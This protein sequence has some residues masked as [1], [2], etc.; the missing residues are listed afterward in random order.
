MKSYTILSYV[1]ILFYITCHQALEIKRLFRHSRKFP[2]SEEDLELTSCDKRIRV[3]HNISTGDFNESAR[4]EQ[5]MSSMTTEEPKMTEQSMTM[6]TESND[7]SG[8]DDS[9]ESGDKDGEDATESSEDDINVNAKSAFTCPMRPGDIENLESQCVAEYKA[10]KKAKCNMT[11]L[12]KLS[13]ARLQKLSS[14]IDYSKQRNGQQMIGN[15]EKMKKMSAM[16]SMESGHSQHMGKREA[17]EDDMNNN[18]TM[19]STMKPMRRKRSC[20]YYQCILKKMDVLDESTMLPSEDMFKTWVS[21][22][23]TEEGDKAKLQ[24]RATECF[25]DLRE[26]GF[27]STDNSKSEEVS[28]ETPSVKKGKTS[29]GAALKLIKCLS[30]QDTECPVFKFP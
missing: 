20:H 7:S 27:Y 24:E 12:W 6:T 3:S 25:N 22:N 17:P 14:F 1:L 13:I 26:A 18:D 21:N 29:C 2:G 4:P 10:M 8:E 15:E 5:M 9:N 28:A 30:K 19:T 23:V 16:E 11:G